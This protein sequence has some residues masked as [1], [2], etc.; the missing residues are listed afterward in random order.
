MLRQ[1]QNPFRVR[2]FSDTYP[3]KTR[4]ASC[5]AADLGATKAEKVLASLRD[6][7]GR[8]LVPVVIPG[9]KRNDHRLPSANP[10][11]WGLHP[12]EGVRFSERKDF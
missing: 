1:G 8:D 6:A 3:E 11:G 10:S 9:K 2:P 4:A 7:M 5:A 12:D